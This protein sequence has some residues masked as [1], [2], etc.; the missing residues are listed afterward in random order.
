MGAAL[1]VA[2]AVRGRRRRVLHPAGRTFAGEVELWGALGDAAEAAGR[3]PAT[4]RFSK[5]VGLRPGRADL[6]GFAVRVHAPGGDRDLLYSTAGR[7][8]FTR[9]LPTPRRDFHTDYGSIMGYRTGGGHVYLWAAP[10]PGAAARGPLPG[11]MLLSAQDHRERRVYG[12]VTLGEPLTEQADAALTFDPVRN[13]TPGLH[14]AGL[15]HGS[16]RYAYPLSQWWRG[17]RRVTRGSG[18]AADGRV[19]GTRR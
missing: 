12:R 18:D 11:R 10:E 8:R 13:T 16:R 19:S 17:A 14:P 4:V 15:I 9:H 1:V 3:Y 6:L 5:G 2:V 7:G